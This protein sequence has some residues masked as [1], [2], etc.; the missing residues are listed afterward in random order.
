MPG[1]FASL[2]GAKI[3]SNLAILRSSKRLALRTAENVSA[4]ITASTAAGWARRNLSSS[5]EG[6]YHLWAHSSARNTGAL[7]LASLHRVNDATP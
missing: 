7:S 4:H 5:G 6:A 1:D 3:D 2:K